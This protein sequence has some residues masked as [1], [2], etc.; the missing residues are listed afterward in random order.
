MPCSIFAERSG[1]EMG[2]G[3]TIPLVESMG[4]HM[5]S[6]PFISSTIT[7]QAIIRGGSV[8]QQAKWL[9]GMAEGSIGTMALLDNEDWGATCLLYTSPSPRD[10]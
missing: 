2:I 4:R 9:P 7:A 5:L 8:A 3:A 6:T 10:S 1:S